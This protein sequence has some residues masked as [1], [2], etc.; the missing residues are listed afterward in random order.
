MGRSGRAP[1]RDLLLDVPVDDPFEQRLGERRLEP[2]RRGPFQA[3]FKHRGN[4]LGR[5]Y[6][7]FTGLELGRSLDVLQTLHQSIEN[8]PIVPV[9]TGTDIVQVCTVLRCEWWGSGCATP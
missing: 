6:R 7:F 4:P 9:D 3:L 2:G 8:L 5:R 1:V